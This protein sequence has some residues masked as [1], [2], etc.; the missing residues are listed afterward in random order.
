MKLKTTKKA[1]FENYP[2]AR[3][4]SIGYCD[5]QYLFNYCKPIAYTCGVYGWNADIYEID[6]YV[7][8]SGY[9]SFGTNVKDYALLCN[10]E[11]RATEIICDYKK[12]TEEQKQLIDELIKELINSLK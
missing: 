2:K 3:I 6:G 9:R 1:I 4:F 7:F 10:L 8:V 11:K 12:S 5:V